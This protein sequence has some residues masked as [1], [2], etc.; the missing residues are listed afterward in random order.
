MPQFVERFFKLK[1]V[2]FHRFA[3]KRGDRRT[4]SQIYL[5]EGKGFGVLIGDEAAGQ[6]EAW[7]GAGGG[8]GMRSG[9]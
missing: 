6:T 4:K 2:R 1:H 5:L 7:R 3:A 9:D 8:A